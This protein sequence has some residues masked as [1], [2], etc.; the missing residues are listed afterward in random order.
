[1]V[2]IILGNLRR[3]RWVNYF[4]FR[5]THLVAIAVISAEAWFGLTCPLTTLEMS[6]R[7]QGGGAT[8]SGGFIEHWL[9]Q[10]L[11]YNAPPWVFMFAYSTFALLVLATWYCF[12]P[13][14]RRRGD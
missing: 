5:L 9:H 10:R 2:I 1:M 4:W 14:K 12:P 7:S 13:G 3:W 11:F 6:L 8:Y